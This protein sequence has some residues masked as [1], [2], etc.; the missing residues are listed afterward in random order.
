M[1]KT[2][3]IETLE[4]FAIAIAIVVVVVVVALT[5]AVRVV[6]WPS[7]VVLLH[8]SANEIHFI[9]RKLSVDLLVRVASLLRDSV[10]LT[11]KEI[12]CLCDLLLQDQLFGTGNLDDLF[13]L[14]HTSGCSLGV[15]LQVATQTVDEKSLLQ[16]RI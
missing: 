12:R 11:T 1:T 6:S 13:E 4:L 5:V 2:L 9:V 7:V 16:L 14:L 15:L 3:A 8:H 10:D